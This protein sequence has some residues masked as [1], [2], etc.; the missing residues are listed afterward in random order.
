MTIIVET[1]YL[2][3]GIEFKMVRLAMTRDLRSSRREMQGKI[4]SIFDGDE[5]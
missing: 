2:A 5:P 1:F 4:A 3:L